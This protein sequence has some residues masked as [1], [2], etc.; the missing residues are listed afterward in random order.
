M[1]YSLHED[2]IRRIKCV[3]RRKF[4]T[5]NFLHCIVNVLMLLGS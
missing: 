4:V 3:I 5:S 2:V 1:S